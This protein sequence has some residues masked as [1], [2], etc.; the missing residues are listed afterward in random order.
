M[1]KDT[2]AV[3]GNFVPIIIDPDVPEPEGRTGWDKD[4]S[5]IMILPK[6]KLYTPYPP[7]LHLFLEQFDYVSYEVTLFQT[8]LRRIHQEMDFRERYRV[9]ELVGNFT[10]IFSKVEITW[11][12]ISEY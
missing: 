10:I 7:I 12:L 3:I 8:L 11:Q 2:S 6:E 5:T 1:E 9:L 4:S